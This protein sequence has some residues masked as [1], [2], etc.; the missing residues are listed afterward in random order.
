MKLAILAIL[1]ILG[2]CY[3][4][5]APLRPTPYRGPVYVYPYGGHCHHC[6]RR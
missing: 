3:Y 2:G 1:V 4:Q 6:W 5:T